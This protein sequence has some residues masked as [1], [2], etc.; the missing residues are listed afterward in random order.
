MEFRLSAGLTDMTTQPP[1]PLIQGFDSD[2]ERFAANQAATRQFSAIGDVHQ[3]VADRLAALDAGRVLDLGGGVV[4]NCHED[5]WISV[6]THWTA[7]G[8]EVGHRW[9]GQSLELV[10]RMEAMN[11]DQA[12]LEEF[13]KRWAEAELARDLTLLDALAHEDFMLVGPLGFVI[14]K[15]QWLDRYRSGDLVTS[16]LQWRDTEARVFGDCAVVGVH[17]QEAAY[18]GR[19]NNGQFRA[20]HILVRDDG[21]WRL[22]GMHLSPIATPPGPPQQQG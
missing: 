14:D 21:S 17:D 13:G 12:E 20:T 6:A 16:S 11:D 5:L 8:L 2:P 7:G 15:A 10:E 19:P 9:A 3:Q 4:V 22:V 18:R 1:R